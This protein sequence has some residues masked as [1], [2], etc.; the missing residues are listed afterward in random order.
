M[1]KET[2]SQYLC[3]YTA[4]L[5]NEITMISHFCQKFSWKLSLLLSLLDMAS[6]IAR[7]WKNGIMTGAEN[8]TF[9]ILH[10]QELI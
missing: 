10:N 4:G 1:F 7:S 6:F 8:S 3:K 2:E 9:T 5:C